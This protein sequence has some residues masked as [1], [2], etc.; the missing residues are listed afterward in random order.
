MDA[1]PVSPLPQ[2][3]AMGACGLGASGDGS[4]LAEVAA[5]PT[6]PVP[7]PLPAHSQ[8][9]GG[10]LGPSSLFPRGLCTPPHTHLYSRW[11]RIWVSYK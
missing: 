5:C 10:Q 9:V 1:P 11:L 7:H 4:L 3:R 2:G 6:C 8:A